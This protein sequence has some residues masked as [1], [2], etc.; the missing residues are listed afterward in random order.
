MPDTIPS[1]PEHLKRRGRALWRGVHRDYILDTTHDRQRLLV[2]C[3]A[4]DRLDEA[5]ARIEQDGTYVTSPQGLKAHPA[6]KVEQD[7]RIILLRALR[8]LGVDVAEPH[9]VRPPSRWQGK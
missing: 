8:E 7:S 3:E 9:V 2:A 6:V 1:P 4:A 5:R